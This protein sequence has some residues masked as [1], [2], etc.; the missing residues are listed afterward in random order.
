MVSSVTGEQG[1][2]AGEVGLGEV[3]AE[4][5]AVIGASSPDEQL[6]RP[7]VDID[8]GFV[9]LIAGPGEGGVAVLDDDPKVGLPIGSQ[10]DVELGV[11]VRIV[12][13]AGDEQDPAELA[14]RVADQIHVAE[15]LAAGF[16]VAGDVPAM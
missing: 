8:R 12:T 3:A 10:P 4:P 14:D 6:T 16:V 2:E 13:A 5:A 7:G 11:R 1:L 15:Q 9:G